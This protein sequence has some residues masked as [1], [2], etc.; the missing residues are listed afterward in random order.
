MRRPDRRLYSLALA[1]ALAL[2]ALAG[3]GSGSDGV[4]TTG[5]EVPSAMEMTGDDG[6]AWSGPS[7]ASLVIRPP[8]ANGYGVELEVS[9]SRS[10]DALTIALTVLIQ[11]QDLRKSMNANATDAPPEPYAI[12][13]LDPSDGGQTER[14]ASGSVAFQLSAGRIAGTVTSDLA[15]AASLQFEG[16]LA[17]RCETELDVAAEMVD[18]LTAECA[19]A[20]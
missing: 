3:C 14:A 11:S 1:L 17:V 15:G 6:S 10:D 9:A 16:D 18:Y 2:A 12:I 8:P 5:G 4:A 19:R 20:H 7:P 13:E